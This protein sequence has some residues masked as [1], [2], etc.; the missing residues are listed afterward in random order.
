MSS[1]AG[2]KYSRFL[3]PQYA[4]AKAGLLGF[5]KQIEVE[6][7]PYGICLNAIAPNIVLTEAAV[8]R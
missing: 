7:G 4:A 8:V 5:T 6:L 2:R 3:G 1:F